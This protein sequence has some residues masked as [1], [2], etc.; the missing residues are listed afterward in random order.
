MS[1]AEIQVRQQFGL[2]QVLRSVPGVTV[3]QSGGPG[4][5]T[6]LF[7]RG[8]ESDQTLVLVD[9]V[10]ANA[11]GGGIDLSQIP[12]ADVERIEIVRGPQSA[13]YGAD[14]I[15]GV[16]Q[17]VTRQG[18]IPRADASFEFG[19]REMRRGTAS[20]NGSI[21]AIRWHLGGDYFEDEGYTGLASNGETV[22][23][24]DAAIG[25]AAATLGWAH[26]PSGGDL[27]GSMR[28]VDTERGTPGPFGSDPADRFFG[29]DRT[30]RNLTTRTSGALRWIQPWF[31]P[32]SRVRQRVEFDAADYELTYL[33]PS[34]PP[35]FD[36][37]EG[38]TVRQHLRVQTDLAA[39]AAVG[40]TAGLEWLGEEGSS[41]YIVSGDPSQPM[42]VDRSVLGIFGEARWSP[43]ARFSVSAGVRGER[44]H[45]GALPGD[46]LAFTPRPDFP[47]ETIDSLNP[48][49][50]A[51]WGLAGDPGSNASTRLHGAF[52]T[53]IR[54][55]DAFEMAFTDNPG[56][57]PERSRSADIGLEQTLAG[58]RG[59]SSTRPPSSTAS[60]TSSSRSAVLL[61]G[62]AA[63]GPTTSRMREPAA[64]SSRADGGRCA[65]ST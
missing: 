63:G 17:L 36:R 56:L 64:S 46:P 4:S 60:T 33:T 29:V 38:E 31:G 13:L 20:T 2:G 26:A 10:R 48:K 42:D 32:S 39:S 23:N 55:P 61:R 21:D 40:V 30:S 65:R 44:I 5:V 51:N 57:K 37:S 52:G 11:F 3:Q 53:G 58:G 24:D 50:A 49:I 34:S 59:H 45:R 62:A 7:I 27:Q 19:S 8:S 47:A 14:A 28:Y 54:P 22:S 6:S 1:G 25:Q 41:T 16:V 9:G 15:G 12:S 18:G 35:P 43:L